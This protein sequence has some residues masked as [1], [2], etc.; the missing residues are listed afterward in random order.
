M[1]VPKAIYFTEESDENNESSKEINH[2]FCKENDI[3]LD[4]IREEQAKAR[5]KFISLDLD[6]YC[7]TI[8]Q[9]LEWENKSSIELD[10]SFRK[11]LLVFLL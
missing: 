9:N 5:K 3:R 8:I 6:M 2:E 7:V 1:K 4:Q 11:C 10:K